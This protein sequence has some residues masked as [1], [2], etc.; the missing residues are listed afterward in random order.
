MVLLLLV[1]YFFKSFISFLS[2]GSSLKIIV[3]I[4]SSEM[5][6]YSWEILFLVPI[7]F[8]AFFISILQC[9]CFEIRLIASPIISMFLSTAFFVLRSFWYSKKSFFS[10]RKS[11]ISSIDLTMS[12]SQALFYCPYI[13]IFVSS[14]SFLKNWF[15]MP[16]SSTRSIWRLNKF[17]SISLS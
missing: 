1:H 13:R 15:L 8:W 5:L 3:Q 11:K 6:S 17:P 9:S 4:T 2:S 10:G 16:L 7:I 14:S 12:S